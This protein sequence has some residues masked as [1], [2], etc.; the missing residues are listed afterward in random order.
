MGQTKPLSDRSQTGQ[1]ARKLDKLKNHCSG[2]TLTSSR[3][4]VL[5]DSF[6]HK[7]DNPHDNFTRQHPDHTAPTA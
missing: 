6:H 5:P 3:H 4:T 7:K 1:T 2:N